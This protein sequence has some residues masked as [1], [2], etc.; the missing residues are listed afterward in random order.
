MRRL[1]GAVH[2]AIEASNLKHPEKGPNAQ[3]LDSITL[4]EFCQEV[5]PNIGVSIASALTGSL[6]GVEP[7]EV[8]ALYIF[9]YMKSGSGL[10]SIISDEK[11]GA[12]YIRARH[13]KKRMIVASSAGTDMSGNRYAKYIGRPRS[14]ADS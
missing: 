7:Q 5:A 12:Q 14:G 8:S 13:G 1:Y 6:L 3:R 2:Q 10:K 9:N 11:D 4:A